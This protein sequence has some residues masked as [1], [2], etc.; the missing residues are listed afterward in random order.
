V[1]IVWSQAADRDLAR[2]Y[3]YLEPRSL[4]AARGLLRRLFKAID[5]L[6]E[7]P[8][9]GALADLGMERKYRQHVVEHYKIFYYVERDR[10]VIVR[11][12]D[13]RQDPTRFFIPNSP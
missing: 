11:L 13:T 2:I 3:A 9:M 12:W 7:M 5:V 6:A 10:L 8:R 4:R 1:E